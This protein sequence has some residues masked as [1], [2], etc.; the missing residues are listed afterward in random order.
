MAGGPV[1]SL[2]NSVVA[3]L[4]A[5]ARLLWRHGQDPALTWAALSAWPLLR[6]SRR[7]PAGRGRREM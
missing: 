5:L 2:S 7:R 3:L 4:L 6:L 1:A